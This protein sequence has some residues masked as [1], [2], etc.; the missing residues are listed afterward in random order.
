MLA[1]VPPFSGYC[2]THIT[3][4]CKLLEQSMSFQVRI[5]VVSHTL[6]QARRQGPIRLGIYIG[7]SSFGSFRPR[8]VP[9]PANHIT[10]WA[11]DLFMGPDCPI[12]PIGSWRIRG[13][14]IT[15]ITVIS[16]NSPDLQQSQASC[17]PIDD[18]GCCFLA[19]LV[20][21]APALANTALPGQAKLRQRPNEETMHDCDWR[22][23]WDHE[24]KLDAM[25]TIYD[26]Y[27]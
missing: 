12:G 24:R 8:A 18:M 5:G 22:R 25:T 13:I 17:L 23:F 2:F 21:E 16:P 1:F 9:S 10:L 15:Y 20:D 27:L 6:M 26:Y 4:V 19:L 14:C 7:I 3:H 11:G